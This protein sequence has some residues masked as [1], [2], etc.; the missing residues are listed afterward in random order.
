[1]GTTWVLRPGELPPTFRRR[2]S[3]EEPDS[4]LKVH[5]S[6]VCFGWAFF[7]LFVT[8]P[9]LC[10]ILKLYVHKLKKKGLGGASLESSVHLLSVP[11]LFLLLSLTFIM[12]PTFSKDI[13]IGWEGEE[14]IGGRYGGLEGM[15]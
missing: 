8:K 5:F 6:W 11:H 15:G 12:S 7:V 3:S 13:R 14:G 2:T 9:S 1:M 4:E 10:L